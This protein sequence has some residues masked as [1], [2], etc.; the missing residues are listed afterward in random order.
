MANTQP[1]FWSSETL[2]K[3]LPELV[4]EYRADRVKHAAYELS[5]GGEAFVTGEKSRQRLGDGDE[6]VIPPGQ[7][8]LLM[9][10]EAIT[11]PA[12]AIAFISMKSKEKFRGLINVS[13]FHV[14]PGFSGK[15]IFSAF[16]A[17][18]QELH[19]SKGEPLFMIW[20][21]SLDFSTEDVYS[22]M[23]KGQSKLPDY[24]ITNMATKIVS[25]TTLQEE[26]NE[27]KHSFEKWKI[28]IGIVTTLVISTFIWTTVRGRVPNDSSQHPQPIIIVQ[29]GSQIMTNQLPAIN[30]AN[31]PIQKP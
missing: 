31:P 15:L 14:D 22:G 5:L 1:G 27:I 24:V 4:K 12:D 2:R 21:A 19:L 16:N 8:A 17:G 10:D 25:A 13:G 6:V 26:F 30:S 7:F 11:V 18:V 3:R 20:Y 9:T 28:A 23:H 29:P